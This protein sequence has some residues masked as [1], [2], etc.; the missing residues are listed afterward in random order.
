MKLFKILAMGASVFY[1]AVPPLPKADDRIFRIYDEVEQRFHARQVTQEAGDTQKHKAEVQ[2]EAQSKKIKMGRGIGT[3]GAPSVFAAHVELSDGWWRTL[4]GQCTTCT[5]GYKMNQQSGRIEYQSTGGA[6]N[7]EEIDCKKLLDMNPQ[8]K[9][10]EKMSDF[11]K[12]KIA[13]RVITDLTIE[14]Q[15]ESEEDRA[16]KLCSFACSI[17]VGGDPNT[18]AENK[19]LALHEMMTRWDMAL[20]FPTYRLLLQKGANP[21]LMC[22]SETPYQLLSDEIG[23]GYSNYEKWMAELVKFGGKNPHH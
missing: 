5:K 12:H 3:K 22:V 19:H 20:A 23:G 18:R 21:N 4:L 15:D 11:V 9:E 7:N 13:K 10:V 16:R 2:Q 14:E 17:C 6:V 1:K 8:W